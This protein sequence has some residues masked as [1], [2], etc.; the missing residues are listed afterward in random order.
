MADVVRQ[1][2]SLDH[3]WV[4]AQL[5]GDP[6]ADLSD[7]QRVRQPRPRYVTLPGADHLG[8]T[9][10]SSQR[11]GVQDAGPVASKRAAAFRR[12]SR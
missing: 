1:S 8:L 2:G 9:R 5:D 4:T 3:I 6:A 10:Q 12:R 11:R 7:L